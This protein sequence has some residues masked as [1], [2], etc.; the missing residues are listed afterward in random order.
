MD[1][2]SCRAMRGV[3]AHHDPPARTCV[4]DA[5]VE[6]S[7][8]VSLHRRQLAS[9]RQAT[10]ARAGVEGEVREES[11]AM[12]PPPAMQPSCRR[13]ASSLGL[14][15]PLAPVE[16]D[17]WALPPS[18]GE[19]AALHSLRDSADTRLHTAH[20]STSGEPGHLGTAL[21]WFERFVATFPSRTPFVPHTGAGDVHAAAYNEETLRLF[22]EFIRRHGSV[23]R[24]SEGSAVSAA[25][26]GD[27]VASVRS[28]RS[29]EAG[30]NLLVAGGNLRLPLQMRHMRR[31]D[32]PAGSRALSR[33]LTARLLRKLIRVVDFD[34]RGTRYACMRWAILWAGHNMLLRGGEFGVPARKSFDP[35]LGLVLADLDWIEPCEE[36]DWYHAVCVDVMPIKDARVDRQ[37][38]P[39][40]IRRRQRWQATSALGDDPS[41][42]YDAIRIY[43]LLRLQ[44]VHGSLRGSAPLFAQ[45]DGRAVDTTAVAAC[46]RDAALAIGENPSDFDARALRI[47]G[48][49]DLYHLFGA[50]EAERVIADRGRWNSLVRDLYS[51][52]SATSMLRVSASMADATGVDLEAFRHG[53]IMPA[54]VRR[55]S[56]R[57]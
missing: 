25:A 37:R 11:L 10:L 46:I 52:L 39:T 12:P 49:T 9:R 34:T 57:A 56:R 23:R 47:G 1:A 54:L 38:V 48:A 51:R 33:G 26:I 21:R 55:P 45:A 29:R 27:Y 4:V 53:Y 28:F 43:F 20:G 30:Y 6:E 3:C 41:C 24:G 32:G 17:R 13:L 22:A 7:A 19:R 18:G 42:A 50:T 36:T 40:L 31:E 35:A 16:R 15:G 14:T 44:E 8:P 2:D 5:T